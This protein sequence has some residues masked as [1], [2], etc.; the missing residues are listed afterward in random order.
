[1][2]GPRTGS[3]SLPHAKTT[4]SIHYGTALV[5]LVN[6]TRLQGEYYSGRDR[7]TFGS[8]ELEKMNTSL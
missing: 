4:M 5:R 6:P 7:Q 1:M 3:R 2:T 8:I